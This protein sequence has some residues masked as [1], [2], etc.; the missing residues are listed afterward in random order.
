MH[1]LDF[2]IRGFLPD[3]E[4]GQPILV[5]QDDG[6]RFLLPI[7]IGVPEAGAIA[8]VL[9]GQTLARPMT[10]DLLASVI[11]GFGGD[12]VRVDV[13]AIE[14]STFLADLW[15]QKADGETLCLDC[16]P[17]DAIALAVRTGAPIRVASAVLE[18]AQ[19]LNP[20]DGGA[21]DPNELSAE[22]ARGLH[23]VS[24]D[25]SEARARLALALARLDPED[26]GKFKA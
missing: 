20:E 3:P 1:Y 15:L 23:V 5:L 22:A 6:G 7:W 9:E 12:V 13:R 4:S 16:R 25:D 21:G 2:N 8:A 26:F 19:P 17:S 14:D 11:R 10:H 24:A 18:A